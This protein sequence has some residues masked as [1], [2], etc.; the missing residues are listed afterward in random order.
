MKSKTLI[1]GLVVVVLI[2]GG[3]WYFTSSN[4]QK[5]SETTKVKIA[6]L[7]VVHGLPLFTAIEKGYFKEEGIEVEAIKFE[8][9]NQIVDALL[10]G[11]VDFGDA[12]ALSIAGIA[13]NKNPGKI[14]VYGVEGEIGNNSGENIIVPVKSTL[15]S[16]S[17]LK[18]KKFGI[19]A[20]T[21]QWRTIAREVLAKNGLDMDKDLTIVELAPSIQV[22]AL[23]SGQVDAILALEPIPTVAVNQ[24]IG[25]ILVKAPAK[26]FIANPFWYGAEVVGTAFA[27]KNPNTTEKV[28][29]VIKRAIDETNN[30]FD[31]NRQY[32]KNYTSLTEELALK[33]P[34][35]N[36]KTCE[37]L[38]EQDKDSIR[39][40]YTI[41]TKYGVVNGEINLDALLYCK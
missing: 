8:S 16:I 6:Y 35:V 32:L 14:K 4:Q 37:S 18:G 40:F 7:P 22:Q 38:N 33:V 34:P 31:Q 24:S 11:Q 36:Y 25:K 23:A 27:M 21:I 29:G 1:V 19:L 10:N 26:E 20:G 28:I 13:E 3:I 41:F 30:N 12:V 17:E 2:A 5:I 39:K 15:T 9:P